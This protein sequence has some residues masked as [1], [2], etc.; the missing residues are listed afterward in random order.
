MK[1]ILVI[2]SSG[3]I[4]QV[5]TNHLVSSNFEVHA[6]DNLLYGQN[7]LS[8]TQIAKEN[9]YFE[10]LDIKDLFKTSKNYYDSIV[11]LAG[12][13]GDPI[14]KKYPK[15]SIEINENYILDILNNIIK[16]DLCNKTVF[17]STCSNYGLNEKEILNEHS[18]L[19]PL[20]LYA[21]SKVNIEKYII[22]NFNK[23]KFK[24]T[25]LRFATA[26]GLSPRMR[27]DLTLNEF[28]KNLF[29]KK[30]LE[31]YDPDTWRPYCHVLDFARAITKIIDED[32]VITTNQIYNVGSDKNNFTKRDI[33]KVINKYINNIEVI[34]LD[35][36][37]DRRNYRVSFSKIENKLNF[38]AKYSIDFGVKEIIK[39][40]N[41]NHTN[42]E[43]YQSYGN[44]YVKS[45]EKKNI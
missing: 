27:F 20:S 1:K 24:P 18:N 37:I 5:L 41:D 39:F 16:S 42:Y 10:N 26:F 32:E 30:K 40:L 19:Q 6:V 25:I 23:N 29:F 43:D 4:G 3:Y 12:L 15:Q 38:R 31:V 28:T 35:N 8:L 14:T 11:I 33:I 17:I 7:N 34:Y 21:K 22:N 45:F 9:F 44:Y 2:G 36:S 13:V